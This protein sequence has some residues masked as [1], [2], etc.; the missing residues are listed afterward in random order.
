MGVFQQFKKTLHSHNKPVIFTD[1]AN[2]NC[3]H[4]GIQKCKGQFGG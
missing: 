2:L 4:N 3:E 1:F